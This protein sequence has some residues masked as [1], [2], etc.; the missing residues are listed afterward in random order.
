MVVDDD[1]AGNLF[2]AIDDL[3]ASFEVRDSMLDN[4]RESSRLRRRE[5]IA[6][7]EAGPMESLRRGEPVETA[8]RTGAELMGM[9]R[10]ARQAQIT[11]TD[12]A[13]INTLLQEAD[14]DKINALVNAPR[15]APAGRRTA[16]A[17]E[18]VA[19]RA[20]LAAIPQINDR[21]RAQQVLNSL[22]AGG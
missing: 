7:T 6:A 21:D 5:S 19:G 3:K 14:A 17:V 2:D 4:L 16:H 12:E 10:E 15:A 11:S 1:A 22:F 8:K 20:P 18:R 13:L 9:G